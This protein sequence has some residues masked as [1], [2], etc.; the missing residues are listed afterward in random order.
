MFRAVD[1]VATLPEEMEIRAA[2]RGPRELS[3][4][5]STKAE[6]RRIQI[7]DANNRAHQS[8]R[9]DLRAQ[10][11][12]GSPRPARARQRGETALGPPHG[13]AQYAISFARRHRGVLSQGVI[14]D[15]T[16]NER[17]AAS[18]G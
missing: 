6:A 13:F 11:A 15:P 18:R 10:A 9:A 3:A 8:S 2:V 5:L 7:F 4:Y 1:P 14:F 17:F 16:G 12:R